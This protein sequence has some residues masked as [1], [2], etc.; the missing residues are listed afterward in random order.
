MTALRPDFRP[1]AATGS[2]YVGHDCAVKQRL[3]IAGVVVI[4]VLIGWLAWTQVN[5]SGGHGGGTA[6][7]VI[8]R[9]NS[10]VDCTALQGEFDTAEQNRHTDYMQAADARMRAVGCYR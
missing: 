4:V 2:S 1:T 10:E 5:D 3:V 9:I 7:P 8:T 6:N